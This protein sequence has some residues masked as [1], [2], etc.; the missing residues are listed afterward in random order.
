MTQR[1]LMCSPDYFEVHYSI[2]PW[3]TGQ[4]GKV[5]TSLA[6]R[7]WEDFFSTLT[8]FA[9]VKLIKPQ[10]HVPDLVFTANAGLIL[11][12]KFIPSRFRHNERRDEEPFFQDWFQSHGYEVVEWP[13]SVYFEGAGDALLQP[14]KSLL[15]AAH[16]FRTDLKAH[17]ILADELQMQVISLKLVDSRFYHLDTCFCPLLDGR[18]MYYPPAFDQESLRLIEQHT[19]PENRILVSENDGL[20]F[21]CNAVLA[22]KNII[23][24][25]A[26]NDLKN[27]L[28]KAGYAVFIKPVTEFLKAGG[29]NKC[30]TLELNQGTE[31]K[32]SGNKE[33]EIP[34]AVGSK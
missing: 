10:R 23:L 32:R 30:L 17:A 5:D 18:V 15:W 22:G 26:G 25:H 28:E 1:F 29:A 4:I 27:Q 31:E 2:N 34:L 6:T 13:K 3:M 12:N 24:N 14:G 33:D 8:Q 16:G 9:E 20:N 11:K 19:A 7:Q 21:V